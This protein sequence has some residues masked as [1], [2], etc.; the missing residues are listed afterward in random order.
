M[1]HELGF[2]DDDI[3]ALRF[4]RPDAA[5]WTDW[6]C[7][8]TMRVRRSD[9]RCECRCETHN[10]A[11]GSSYSDILKNVGITADEKGRGG[12][13]GR[14]VGRGRMEAR[15]QGSTGIEGRAGRADCVD[16][17]DT[18]THLWNSHC[19]A[20]TATQPRLSGS[21]FRTSELSK[22]HRTAASELV[23]IIDRFAAKFDPLDAVRIFVTVIVE[24]LE[25]RPKPRTGLASALARG[26]LAREDLKQR[27]GGS[28]SAEEARRLLGLSKESVLKRYRNARLL[29]WREARQD[30]VRFP[31][32]QFDVTRADSLLAGTSEVLSI[33]RCSMELDDWG[34][35]LF[36]FNP[37]TSL[38]GKRPLDL[39]REGQVAPVLLAARSCIE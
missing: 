9:H 39:L 25:R 30:A 24:E 34:R 23:P 21:F 36:F 11:T 15:D 3:V 22:R 38:G 32:W 6:E 5:K 35:I 13:L 28:L 29:G 8:A 4:G 12:Q 18:I 10:Q 26:A 17:V 7:A 33:L 19:M 1:R 31:A 20:A 2:D 27:E 37:R 16:K 14:R